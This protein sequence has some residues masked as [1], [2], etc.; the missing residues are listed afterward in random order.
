MIKPT[1][2]RVVWFQPSHP[3]DQLPREQPYAALI[4]YVHSDTCI[5]VGG[6]DQN[7]NHFSACSVKLLQDEDVPPATGYYAMWM[8][9]QKGQ[10]A[11]TEQLENA[12]AAVA[13]TA[14]PEGISAF[15]ATFLG[16]EAVAEVERRQHELDKAK[17]DGV[18]S[19][20][21][22]GGSQP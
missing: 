3:A 7:G 9:S 17:G 13:P 8:P 22:I 15:S 16:P 11:R 20:F 12:T 4:A 14:V 5:N 21:V 10:A 1:I 2:G 19:D 6:F 18:S